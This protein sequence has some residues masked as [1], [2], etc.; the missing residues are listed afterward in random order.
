MPCDAGPR[1]DNIHYI[2][3]ER[4]INEFLERFEKKQKLI[5]NLQNDLDLV[6]KYLC[7]ICTYLD[8]NKIGLFGIISNCDYANEINQWFVKHKIYDV[9]KDKIPDEKKIENIKFKIE[10]TKNVLTELENELEKLCQ[11]QNQK[12]G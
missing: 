12:T 4:V 2:D 10:T 9:W 3:D 8:E 7:A 11:S 6:T 5:L 1:V